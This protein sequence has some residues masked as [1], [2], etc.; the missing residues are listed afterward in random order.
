MRL[1]WTNKRSGA[2]G[3]R[4]AGAIRTLLSVQRPA[5]SANGASGANGALKEHASVATLFT[6]L[7]SRRTEKEE[8]QDGGLTADPSCLFCRLEEKGQCHPSPTAHWRKRA[9]GKNGPYHRPTVRR[10]P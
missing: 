7:S 2:D 3:A 5:V 10:G 1:H 6:C 4:G 9:R 8:R